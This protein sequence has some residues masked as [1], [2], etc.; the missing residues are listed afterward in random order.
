MLGACAQGKSA[1]EIDNGVSQKEEEVPLHT[2]VP[3][4]A[5][6]ADS[7]GILLSISIHCSPA[8][9]VAAWVHDHFFDGFS[10]SCCKAKQV[11]VQGSISRTVT[12]RASSYSLPVT[13]D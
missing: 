4:V 9:G 11:S 7:S 3:A 13:R 10:R 8:S 2:A 5:G 12:S 1:G 6:S